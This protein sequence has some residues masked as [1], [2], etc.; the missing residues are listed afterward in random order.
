MALA[1]GGREGALLQMSVSESGSPP[2]RLVPVSTWESGLQ[3]ATTE[4]CSAGGDFP[5]RIF[6]KTRSPEQ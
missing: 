3:Q 4:G 1:V 6:C 5:Q 2:S